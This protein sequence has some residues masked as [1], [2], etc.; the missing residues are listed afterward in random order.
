MKHFY[1]RHLMNSLSL[2]KRLPIALLFLIGGGILHS[3]TLKGKLDLRFQTLVNDTEL[4]KKGIKSPESTET[5]LLDKKISRITGTE[6]YSCII[7]TTNVDELRK[8]GIEIQSVLPNFVTA[9]VSVE[10]LKNLSQVSTVQSVKSPEKLFTNNDIAV[11]TSGASLLQNGVLN[12]TS[13]KGKGILLGVFD[14]GI[15][16]KHPDFRNATDQTKS[17]ILNLWDQ[18]IT[19]TGTETSP[20]GFT[21]GVEYT[22]A[23][24]NDEIDGTPANFVR[25]SDTSGHGTHVA[26]IAGGNGAALSNQNYVGM[27]PEADY[28]VVKG[29]NGSFSQTGTI[30]A[31]TYFKKIATQLNKPIVVNMSIG[32]Q[33]GPHDGSRPDEVAVDNFTSSANGRV[34][35]IAAGN[36]NGSNIHN[37][38]TLQPNE[39]KT[40]EFVLG[41]D[42]TTKDIFRFISYGNDKNTAKFTT[43]ATAPDGTNVQAVYGNYNS[44]DV[45]SGA[46]KLL[47]ETYFDDGS[48]GSYAY[49]S[50]VRNQIPNSNP[51]AYYTTDVAGTWKL[52]VT[53]TGT[54]PVIL[55]GWL[56]SKGYNNITLTGGDSNYLVGS[57]G[58][59]T[60]AITTAAYVGKLSWFN[61][62]SSGTYTY[63]GGSAQDKIAVFSSVGP[64]KDEVQK[65]DIAADG[66]AVISCLSSGSLPLSSDD[67]PFHVDGT[68]YRVEQG[69][70]MASPAVAGAVAL[71]LQAKPDVSYNA[72]K[73]A[74]KTYATTDNYTGTVPNATWGYGK[75]DVY[76]AT[77]SL[78]DCAIPQRKTI[79]YD[80]SY[81]SN[82]LSGI[83]LNTVIGAVNFTPDLSGKLGGV[84]FH[85][86]NNTTFQ[87][88]I[89]K[90]EI[91]TSNNGIPGD[92]IT[93]KQIPAAKINK[94]SWNYIDLSDLNI[95]VIKGT[96]YAIAFNGGSSGG[97]WG[98]FTETSTNGTVDGRSYYSANGTSWTKYTSDFRI[99]SVVYETAPNIPNLATSHATD[100]KIINSE[101]NF[102]S[103]C[104][105]IGKILPVGANP[106]NGG[107]KGDVWIEATQDPN[108][109]N[110]HY[111]FHPINDGLAK[112]TGKVTLY[113]TQPEF[114]NYNAVNAI[115]LPQNPTDA[116]GIANLLITKFNGVGIDG[117]NLPHAYYGG[118]ISINPVD[119]DIIWDATFNRWQVSFDVTGFGGF[120]VNTASSNLGTVNPIAS[121]LKIYPNPVVN[122]LNIEGISPKTK[123]SVYDMSGKLIKEEITNNAQYQL[124]VSSLPKGN[125]IIKIQNDKVN[126]TKEFIKK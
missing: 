77:A 1:K 109:V 4:T 85:T 117:G 90:I 2:R 96:D 71:M 27:A 57:P 18:T 3:Q 121:A 46:F 75:L 118:S 91:R 21:Y 13:Y 43:V 69:T 116:Q 80:G 115:K 64:R 56:Y 82:S 22:Q 7:Y 62:P 106:I 84:F 81:T 40:F 95:N 24:I 28:V 29:G 93:T 30:D 114:D 83:G 54:T 123:L 41:S 53:N 10:D 12:G 110:R 17:R 49:I 60:S 112:V 32:S 107:V 6:K 126:I 25:E 88:N 51:A 108:F 45:S 55:D 76:R 8:M 74:L 100:T 36:D 101:T 19:P 44:I 70:S 124:S 87:N 26:G 50:L 73:N 66:Q 89:L 35:V 78:L 120:F 16:W 42:T 68:Y 94:F 58:N 23:Q 105:L 34:V 67:T 119:T 111:Q 65:P 86:T 79:S 48:N 31:L 47:T 63:T 20:S 15:D 37:R 61:T 104:S 99:R 92:I 39:T 125:Y 97:N 52:S 38:Q 103:E 98:L 11:G 14:T 72:I 9:L 59:A 113:F 122:F 102:R 33:F 5:L